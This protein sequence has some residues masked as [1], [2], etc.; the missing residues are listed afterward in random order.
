M[1]SI[2]GLLELFG[3]KILFKGK[4]FNLLSRN[5]Y[6]LLIGRP[7]F[8]T[9]DPKSTYRRILKNNYAFPSSVAVS[10]DAKDLIKK[11]LVTDPSQRP[12][13]DEI[14]QHPFIKNHSSSSRQRD[15]A[16]IKRGN[17]SQTLQSPMTYGVAIP[18]LMDNASN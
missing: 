15:Q 1:K 3:K 5:S 10:E 8:E 9:N 4:L 18:S 2:S 14:L 12:T 6:T 7:P 17:T 16:S 13:L 11:I